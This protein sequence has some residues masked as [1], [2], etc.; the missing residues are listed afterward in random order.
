[1]NNSLK[2]EVNLGWLLKL[3]QIILRDCM[4]R[5]GSCIFKPWVTENIIGLIEER[6]KIQEFT[7][8]KKGKAKYIN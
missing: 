6:R 5:R 1:M 8:K 4:C 7:F 3:L 2:R